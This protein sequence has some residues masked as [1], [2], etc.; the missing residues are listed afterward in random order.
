MRILLFT[1]Y[2]EPE[3]GA[4][5]RRW[6]GLVR[7][8]VEHGHE[9]AVCAPIAHYPHRR[10]DALAVERPP[11]WRWTDG[12]QGETVLRV[13]YVPSSGTIPG[14]LID[15][16]VSSLASALAAVTMRGVRPDVLISTTPG[17]P[18]PFVASAVAS[19]LRIPHIAEVRD[20]WPDLIAD[21]SLVRRALG[22]QLPAG[23]AQWLES[24]ALPAVFHSALRSA[25]ALVATT[26]SFA[27]ALRGR[28]MPPVT[29]V[30]NTSDVSAWPP[31]AARRRVGTDLHILYVGTV[32]RS[33]DLES[34]VRAVADVTGVHLRIVGAGAQWEELRGLA[35]TLTDRIEFF[36]QTTG[37]ALESHWAWAH[38]GLVSLADV[39]SFE[40]TVPSKL[41]SVMARRV[42][43][44]GVVAGEA[45]SM[46]R[47]SSGG[48]VSHPGDAGQL[49]RL[50]TALRD[51]PD[52]TLVDDRPLA[53]LRDHASP[54]AAAATYL[55][56]LEEVR[57]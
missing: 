48:S 27:A 26:E 9:V 16:S 50:L 24:S 37:A 57:R 55:N 10:A 49:R 25:D 31:R 52:S 21:S 40:R 7:E 34:V 11:V 41:V 15:Q 33:Q 38:T 35:S 17:L 46:I 44:T 18:M 8:F 28:D 36:P 39:P 54:R 19:A 22:G 47:T 56:L 45:A 14:Q 29:V 51:D 4:P 42:H 30:R 3:I 6:R 20:A 2:Y 12:R 5:Q 23:A 32:G 1:H 13:P 43:V 53:W